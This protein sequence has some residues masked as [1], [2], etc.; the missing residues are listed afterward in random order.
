M[1]EQPRPALAR[2][3]ADVVFVGI[4]VVA[5]ERGKRELVARGGGGLALGG[6]TR[7]FWD[8]FAAE[9]RVARKDPEIPQK[10]QSRR[11]HRG[12]QASEQVERF[13]HERT[14]AVSPYFLQLELEPPVGAT[15]E[16]LLGEGG[17]GDVPAQALDLGAVAAVDLLFGVHVHAA[18]LGNGFVVAAR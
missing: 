10:M 16:A 13:E 18:H 6:N 4:G 3:G 7:R 11:G 8:D 9:S 14:R 15:R 5:A 2:W 12:H 1:R 17:T